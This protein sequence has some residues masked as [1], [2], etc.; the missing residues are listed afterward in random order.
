MR[1]PVHVLAVLLAALTLGTGPVA[2]EEI[3]LFRDFS[4]GM[5][6]QQLLAMDGVYDCSDMLGEGAL[7]LDRVDFLDH[8]WDMDFEFAAN[9]LVSLSLRAPYS[10]RLYTRAFAELDERF[11]LVA[12]QS[13]DEPL[14]L[15][16][17]WRSAGDTAEA[18]RRMTEYETKG[19]ASSSLAYVFLERSAVQ[20]VMHRA[21]SA[22]DLLRLARR[23]VREV[24][25]VLYRDEAGQDWIV[26]SFDLPR[27]HAAF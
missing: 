6:R 15:V 10:Q 17:L 21:S 11:E 3:R 19:M 25:L 2:A 12:L 8:P 18:S 16:A 14:D 20:E 4:F 1:H 23:E 27:L 13:T 7:C 22:A 24:G 9:A 26:L 5:S